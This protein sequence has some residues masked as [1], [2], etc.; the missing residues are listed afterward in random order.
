MVSFILHLLYIG[1][2]LGPKIPKIVP[3]IVR[4]KNV[5]TTGKKSIWGVD[6]FRF[7]G[8]ERCQQIYLKY[9][10]I[11]KNITE[12]EYDIQNNNLLYKTPK[13]LKAILHFVK[14]NGT[15]SKQKKGRHVNSSF[16][17]RY[18]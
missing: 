3:Q 15:C 11:Y 1:D 16:C 13:I 8:V 18:K 10:P 9:A 4:T 7:W 12:S 2:N 5:H 17:N 14:K 6:A